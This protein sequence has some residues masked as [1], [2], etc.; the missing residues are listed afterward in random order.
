MKCF[1][2]IAAQMRQHHMPL[3]DSK[4]QIKVPDAP[5]VLNNALSYFLG[6]ENAEAQWLPEY[7]AVADWLTDNQGRGLFLFGSCGRGKSLLCRYVLPAI[8]LSCHNKIA[9]VFDAQEMNRNLDFALSRHILSLDDIGTE[10]ISNVYGNKRMAFA[11]LM[12]AAEKYDKLLIVSTNL[13]VAEIQKRYGDRVL[14]RIKSTTKR[15]LFRGDSL[16]K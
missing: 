3:P 1:K 10:E 6:T 12:D 2:E 15:V 7:E 5:T 9:S 8:L 11:E 14:E 4:V 16:R 13:S